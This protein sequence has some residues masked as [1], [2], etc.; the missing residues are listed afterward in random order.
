MANVT[1]TIRR[2]RILLA[3]CSTF[4][5]GEPGSA[6]LIKAL[7]MRGID[8]HW[9]IWNDE[10]VDWTQADLI[11]V[12]STWDYQDHLSDFLIWAKRVNSNLLHGPQ[13]FQW[14]SSK[15]YLLDLERTGVPVVP[16]QYVQTVDAIQDAV[17]RQ[18]RCV[19]KPAV[20]GGGVGV[21][22]VEA[23]HSSW[24][25]SSLGPWIVQPFLKSVMEEGETTVLM[26]DGRITA[27]L[28][29][30]AAVGEFRVHEERGGRSEQ[31]PVLEE[32]QSVATQAYA[33]AE[34]IL[35]IK[36]SYARIDMLRYKDRLVVSELEIIEPQFYF[37]II[38]EQADL[39]ADSLYRS[40]TRA[41]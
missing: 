24:M 15:S 6:S 41:S 10:D 20:G 2:L 25:P 26:I 5:L 34:D 32:A 1:A 39:F 12:R 35:Q 21:E 14:N 31:V 27:Q 23:V 36:L 16:T 17:Q 13:A 40:V 30:T 3:T 28:A 18:G 8:A 11:A 9:V 4:P 22:I 29:K 33:A 19:V 38:R 7:S 37:D